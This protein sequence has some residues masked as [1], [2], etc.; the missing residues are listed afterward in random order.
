MSLAPLIEEVH[1]QVPNPLCSTVAEAFAEQ[2]A[3]TPDAIAVIAQDGELTYRALDERSN[4]LAAHLRSLGVRSDTLVGIAVGR[5]STLVSTLLGILKA[6][7]AY[8]PLDPT[9][10]K[11]RLAWVIADSEMPVLLTTREIRERLPVGASSVN[12]LDVYDPSIAE[13]STHSFRADAV[14]HD[15]AYVTYTSGSTGKPKG[16]MVENRNVVNFF[17]G[18]DNAIGRDPGTWLAVTSVSFDISVLELL[19]TLTR[20]FTVVVHDNE[21]AASIADEVTRY[22]VTHMQ[23]TPSLARILTLDARTFAA[24]ASLKK[25]LLG[26]EVVPSS[27]IR[28]LRQV[29]NGEIYN[30]YGPT[31]T[32]IWSTCGRVDEVGT[33][34]SIGRPISNTQI[35][36]L[37]ADLRRVA[38][39]EAGELFIAGEGVARGYWHRP[40]LTADRFLAISA[41]ADS[42]LYRTGDLVR[43]LSDGRLDF[44]GRTDYQ[45]KLRGHRIEVV[46]IEAILEQCIGIHRAVVVLREDREGDKR[47][48]A[49][50]VADRQGTV[51]I[52]DL[53]HLLES[54]LPDY[55][56]P[57]TF[58]WLSQLPL[59]DNGKIDRK[60][61]LKLSSPMYSRAR[62]ENEGH[63]ASE[64]ERIVANI[65][66]DALGVATVGMNDNFFDLGAHSLTV[67][68]VH[69]RL[70]EALKREFALV[71]LFQF[72]TVT[73]L[74]AHLA[75]TQLETRTADR[76]ERRRLALQH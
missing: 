27:L 15:L 10:P 65:W 22:H 33:T 16:V 55:M 26:G 64:I 54:K 44:L 20:G 53:R 67:A 63:P 43:F 45:I 42:R 7:G 11:E 48:V 50:L 60:A 57:S 70:Q 37:D 18:M 58:V 69:A 35:F 32:T 51:S 39:S 21:G 34:I 28:H 74:A 9:H 40:D 8:V 29:F 2:V 49:Y 14:G 1:S 23:M 17:S 73:T 68:E 4:R 31:E 52:D 41:L 13:C 6:G 24:L 19:W 71:D 76:G 56:I 12:V 75:G 5:S 62:I 61:L 47:L 66:K 25:I 59:T 30:M 3:R 36:V 46:E 38:G 72:S